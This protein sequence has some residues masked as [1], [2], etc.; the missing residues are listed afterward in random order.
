MW[1]TRELFGDRI[2]TIPSYRLL[3]VTYSTACAP[4]IAIRVRHQLADDESRRFPQAEKI[5]KTS[6]Y[7]D[8]LLFGA[9][10]AIQLR[11]QLND[12]MHSGG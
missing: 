3:T 11:A 6:S 12:L 4:Y 5:L 9:S 8:D 7:V 2:L 10:S 1:I